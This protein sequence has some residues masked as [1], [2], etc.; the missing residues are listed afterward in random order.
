M[1]IFLTHNSLD[2]DNDDADSLKEDHHRSDH[3][4]S[5]F[6]LYWDWVNSLYW[7]EGVDRKD[8]DAD[9][10]D[11]EG[12]W[13]VVPEVGDQLPAAARAVGHLE[14]L[15][16]AQ[17]DQVREAA[18]GQRGAAWGKAILYILTS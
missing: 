4:T 13:Q 8:D 6:W 15:E 11:D 18:R 12:G 17:L 7:W 10:L 3:Q 5:E 9:S 1:S 2:D 16:A 14:L